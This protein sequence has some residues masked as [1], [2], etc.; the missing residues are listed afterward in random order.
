[1]DNQTVRA[2]L[3]STYDLGRQPFGLASPTAWLRR[4]GVDVECVD[5]SRDDLSDAQILSAD[6][7]GFYLPMHTATRLAGPVIDRVRRAHPD[8][9]VIAY[10]LYAPLNEKWLRDRGV[11]YVLG[12][13]SEE[14]L[15]RIAVPGLPCA[16]HERTVE[17]GL[18]GMSAGGRMGQVPRA[19][20]PPR[21]GPACVPRLAFIQPD[22]STL[23]PLTRYAAVQMPDGSR[24]VAGSTDATRGCK[25]LC[26]HCPIVPVYNGVFRVIPI[27][28]VLADIRAQVNAGARHISFGDPD[29]LN[30]PTH[31]Q[32]LVSQLARE[33]PGI[34]YDATIKIE[35]IVRRPMLLPLLRDT[36]CLFVTSAVES[37]DDMV[38]EKLRKGH[39]RA[40]FVRAVALCRDAGLALSPTFVPFTPW[41]TVEGYAEL[42]NGLADLELQA[43]VAPIQLAIRLLVTADSALFELPD[44]RQIVEPFDATSL[45]W[46]WRH[47]DPRVDT[48]QRN[49]MHVVDSMRHAAREEV[50]GEVT[51]LVRGSSPTSRISVP[52]K[53]PPF[54]TESWYCCAEPLSSDI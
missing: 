4:A 30:A 24:R 47:A 31:A 40:D 17:P 25:H 2:I 36:G 52:A 39:T 28:V 6:I 22:R 48:L 49:V 26:R 12:P 16:E 53:R 15:V 43:A 20:E 32:R 45:T 41:T 42:L 9:R 50:F 10:G 13:E 29:F 27:D 14:D 35:H 23:P 21:S 1:M 5:A 37:I 33:F 18:H 3:I 54:M 19:F 7:V 44:I 8:A 11:E 51:K 46:P 38:L 34:T